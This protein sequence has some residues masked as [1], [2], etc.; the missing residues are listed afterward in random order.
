MSAVG[1]ADAALAAGAVGE[2]A[3]GLAVQPAKRN[4]TR[5]ALILSILLPRS[6][7]LSHRGRASPA[8]YHR[9]GRRRRSERN[10]SRLVQPRCEAT[11]A[12][13][14]VSRVL[15]LRV[16]KRA[17][18]MAIHLWPS[19]TRRLLRPTRGLG[20]APLPRTGRPARV[21]PSYSALLRVEFAAFHSA[22][23]PEGRSAASSLW[24]C[25]SSHD[26]R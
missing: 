24:H 13:R 5:A 14:S 15:S 10:R 7:G 11:S 16:P 21:A 2:G 23:R 3:P 4:A 9:S 6:P 25:S 17:S 22:G 26:G 20:S 8:H 12:R 18:G 19:V 1:V